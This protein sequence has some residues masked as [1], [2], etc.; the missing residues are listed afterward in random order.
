MRERRVPIAGTIY[1]REGGQ[2]FEHC[3]LFTIEDLSTMNPDSS[4]P[5]TPEPEVPSPRS[6]QDKLDDLSRDLT[7][8]I[9]KGGR[10][11]RR[12]FEGGIPKV[13]SDFAKGLHDIAYAL[14]YATTF[15]AAILREATPDSV[16]SG[17][18]DGSESGRRA[19]DRVA[20]ERR[21]R[22]EREE[23]QPP[24]GEPESAWV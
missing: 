13:K 19:A 22:A 18:R 8:A 16:Q 12:A 17:F 15:G 11:A 14:G 5:T 1:N 2:K 4:E 20:R 24:S 21:E 3:G 9:R 6:T 10:D 23:G 7:E